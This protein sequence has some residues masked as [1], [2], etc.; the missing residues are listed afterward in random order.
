LTHRPDRHYRPPVSA[1]PARQTA[2]AL[3]SYALLAVLSFLPQSLS[4]HD[5]VAYVGDP[6]ESVY[7]VAWNVHQFWS[8]PARLFQANILYPAPDALTLTDHRL[9]PSLLVSPVIWATRNPV[10]AYNVAVALACVLCAYAARRLALALGTTLVGAWAAGALYGFHTYQVNE[11]ARLHIV[12]HAFLPLALLELVRFLRSG[13]ARHAWAMAALALAQGLSSNYFLLYTAL[14]LGLCLAIAVAARP[15]ETVR[16]LPWLAAAGA[17]AG[18]LFLP[19]ALPYLRSARTPG[20]VRELPRGIDLQHYVSTARTNLLYGPIGAEVRMQQ[21]GPHFVGFAALALAALAVAAWAARRGQ[22]P[23]EAPMDVRVWVP[24]AAALALLF[25][26]L[27]LGRD[28][29]VFGRD[30]GPGPYRLLHAYV[31]GFQLVRIPERLG[32]VAMLFVALLAGRGLDLVRARWAPPA[33]LLALLVPLEHLSL[34]NAPYRLPVGRDV[35]AVYR[36]L[37]DTPVRG[38]V[39][40][41]VRGE[42]VI[43]QET[44]EMYFSTYNWRPLAQGYS[45]YPPL[46]S[47]QL[48][49]HAAEFPSEGSLQVLQRAGIDTAVVHHGRG[50]ASE[51]RHQV[52]AIDADRFRRRV[53]AADLDLYDQL[54]PAVAAG[55][56]TRLARFEGAAPRFESTADEV[57]RIAPVEPW[58]TAPFPTGRRLVDPSWRYRGTTGDAAPA[59][60]G[61]LA[62]DWFVDDALV[63]DEAFQVTFP[64]PLRVSGLV[65]PLRR[66]SRFPTRFRVEGRADGSWIPLARFDTP[67][68]LQLVDR[69]LADPRNA[70]LGFDLGGREV[71]GLALRI[72]EGGTSFEGWR[73]P[74]VEVWV[75]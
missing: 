71:T 45:G 19:I 69:L 51:L 16:R 68:A 56:I 34:V 1:S 35:P 22:A 50:V 20:Y 70:A 37:A 26:A 59:T 47:H 38:L 3:A 58:P 61:D 49:R 15:R 5:S 8:D 40:L 63:G 21:Q 30:L 52:G 33:L 36:W 48:R 43:R 24:A 65:L 2:L 27:S 75:P 12:F 46:L 55:R 4:P 14:T 13:R 73:L 9:L 74:E 39:D 28:V 18:A 54:A 17:V 25:V 31:P 53:R 60:D 64:A 41:P 57:Y 67:H 10:L 44:L 72:E 32:L 6:V 11:A 62:T 66:D 23:A 29:L 7:L 42:H